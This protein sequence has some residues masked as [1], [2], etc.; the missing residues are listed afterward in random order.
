M[1]RLLVSWC[2]RDAMCLGAALSAFLRPWLLRAT[3]SRQ[4][5]TA[6]SVALLP[7]LMDQGGI[8]VTGCEAGLQFWPSGIAYSN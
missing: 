7:V 2:D 8:H 1:V 6:R 4:P 3:S 5:L